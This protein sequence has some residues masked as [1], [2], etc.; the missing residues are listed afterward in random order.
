M[1]Y[2]LR[3]KTCIIIVALM[4]MLLVICGTACN[5][6]VMDFT[7]KF[8]RAIIALPDG[9]FVEGKVENWKDWDDGSDFIQVKVN[10]IYYYTHASNVVLMTSGE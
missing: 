6:Q 2:K 10:S 3:K 9:T 1:W 5:R 8:D 7:Y 4:L